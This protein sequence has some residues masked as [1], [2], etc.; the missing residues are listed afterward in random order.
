MLQQTTKN[1]VRCASCHGVN[2]ED[3][4]A[5]ALANQSALAH[6]KAEFIRYTLEKGR[7][8]TPMLSCADLLSGADINN[9]TA[10]ICSKARDWKAEIAVLNDLLT[11]DQ[12][13]LNK[14]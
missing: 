8:G 7:D 13:V 6:N 12:Y 9:V 2:G 1:T 10:S 4:N 11:P 14:Q 5:P 3:I